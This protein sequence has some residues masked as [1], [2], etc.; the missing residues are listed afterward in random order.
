MAMKISRFE[1]KL[2]IIFLALLLVP[3]A[4]FMY[5][6]R[7]ILTTSLGL[8]A[9]EKMEEAL[10]EGLEM[11]RRLVAIEQKESEA[12]AEEIRAQLKVQMQFFDYDSQQKIER[13]LQSKTYSPTIKSIQIIN[14]EGIPIWTS[15]DKISKGEIDGKSLIRRINHEKKTFSIINEDCVC[16]IAPIMNVG[17]FAG[18]VVVSKNIES[19]LA[20]GINDISGA[21]KVYSGLGILHD[22]LQRTT[23]MVIVGPVLFFT[24]LSI[25]IALF[26]ARSITKPIL[27]L[28]KGAEE[29]AGGNLDYQVQTRAKG[30]IG[31]LVEAFNS[32]TI[33][34]KENRRKLLQ[35]E[36]V[37]AW[38]DIA[39]RIAHEIKNPL[40]PIQLAIF[41]LRRNLNTEDEKY[42]K[43]FDECSETI[44][45]EIENLRN[46]ADEFSKFARM[47]EPKF[48]LCD[49]NEL[50]RDTLGLYGNLPNNINIDAE[51]APDLPQVNLDGGQIKQVLHNIIKNA[52]E[53]MPDGGKLQVVTGLDDN[54]ISIGITD[55]GCGMSK[56]VKSKLF[57][58]YF[59]TKQK[60]TGLGMAIVQRIVEQHDGEIDIE[61]QEGVGTTVRIFL[62]WNHKEAKNAEK[63]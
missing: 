14:S 41:R 34:L 56:E 43:L 63:Q 46:L 4:T 29:V 48:Q 19:G 17:D 23:W 47:P 54:L 16:S 27:I 22:D 38:R 37:A 62:R 6:T 12:V 10:G 59:T 21:L 9:N 5:L 49:V 60:G 30:E 39:R 57:T 53:A 61:S 7:R 20:K 58:P 50:V 28:V 32:M 2:I 3:T 11:A 15:T 25:V 33:D 18:A 55:T 1:V 52:I 44:V 42:T 35:A 26:L 51:F 8:L 24:L 45:N 40:T 36:R 13:Y 31:T